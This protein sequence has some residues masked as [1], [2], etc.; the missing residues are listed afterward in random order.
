MLAPDTVAHCW[1]ASC[2]SFSTGT[3]VFPAAGCVALASVRRISSSFRN[4]TIEYRDENKLQTKTTDPSMKKPFKKY[5]RKNVN[6]KRAAAPRKLGR[7]W[8]AEHS[9]AAALV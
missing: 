4:F 8:C 2:S 3:G 1:P 6:G 5:I 7:V 9:S